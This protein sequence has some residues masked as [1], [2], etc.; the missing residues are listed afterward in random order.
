HIAKGDD[1][2]AFTRQPCMRRG[3]AA[4]HNRRDGSTAVFETEINVTAGSPPP[5]ANFAHNRDIAQVVIPFKEGHNIG[6][7]GRNGDRVHAA[8]IR[9]PLVAL[10]LRT[11][12]D[13]AFANASGVL[14]RRFYLALA[15]TSPQGHVIH[16]AS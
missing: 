9:Y 4:P 10:R 13:T 7:Q 11:I 6:C 2:I 15:A 5:V 8:G 12:L 14:S 1:L 16:R 3:M